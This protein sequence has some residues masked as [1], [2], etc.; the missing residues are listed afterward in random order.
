MRRLSV[1]TKLD[2]LQV[3]DRAQKYFEESGLTLVETVGHLHGKGGFTEIRVSGGKLVGNADFDSKA[4]LDDLTNTAK[5][6]FGFEIV[7]FSLHYHATVGYVDVL[8]SNEKPAE[9]ILETMEYEYQVNRFAESLP[10]A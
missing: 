7:S 9:V 5:V 3:F 8:I 4:V 1:R 6:K 10:K 2:P